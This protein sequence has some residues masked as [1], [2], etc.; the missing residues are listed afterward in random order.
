MAKE[1]KTIDQ[2]VELMESRGIATNEDTALTLKR[3]SY[4]AIINGYK[5]PFLDR[6]A[7]KS[8]ADDI[9]LK[10]TTF[11]QI[12]DLFMFDRHLR[13]LTFPYLTAAESVLKN[14]FVYAFCERNRDTEAYLERSNYTSAKDMLVPKPYHGNKTEEHTTNM[15]NL[16]KI[17]NGKLGNQKRMRPFVRHYLNAYGKVPLW[18]LQND[19]TFGNM[20][21]FYQLQKRGVQNAACKIV[22]E[23]SGMSVRLNPHD[24][25][26]AFDVLVGFRNICAHDERLYCATVKGAKF[27]DMFDEL[28]VVLPEKD[29][30]A[31]VG[32]LGSLVR[33]YRGRISDKVLAQVNTEMGIDPSKSS[34][35][36]EQAVQR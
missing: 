22:G 9:Y 2:L 28:N 20:A 12:Y 32:A 26:R 34:W 14:A 13:E 19:L 30:H 10:G 18:V 27:A 11:Q 21:H 1:F 17:L 25:L 23:I 16:M 15:A 31:M 3:E 35:M 7:M 33:A 24:L 36:N 4:Y 29:T 6:E 8:S 5:A